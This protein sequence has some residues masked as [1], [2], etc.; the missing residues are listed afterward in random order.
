[1]A[2]SRGIRTHRR[3]AFV[4]IGVVAALVAAACG[5]GSKKA[6][7]STTET[8]AAGQATETSTTLAEGTTAPGETTTTGPAATGGGPATTTTAKASGST[9]K[10]TTATTARTT[11]QT[12]ASGINNVVGG[13]T[14]TA[15]QANVQVGG[16]FTYLNASD[17]A[18][19]DADLLGT[20]VPSDG[21]TGAALYDTLMYFNKAG[22]V[23]PQTAESLTSTDGL[24][25]TLKLR[26]NIKFTDGTPYDAAAVKFNFARIGDPAT[27]AQNAAFVSSID[28]MDVVDAQTLKITL[29]AKSG[30]FPNSVVPIGFVGS[31][32]AIQKDP[33][34]FANN[35]I[36]AGPFMFKS[37]VRNS[38]MTLVRNPN[39]WNAPEPYLDQLI[40]KPIQDEAQRVNTLN[41]GQA[42]MLWTRV[43]T[44]KA[45]A[46]GAGMSANALI[47]NGGTNAY[48]N[49]TT[50]P[51][52]DQ[53]VR[54][55]V[56]RAIDRAA[57]ANIV[58]QNAAPPINSIF[59]EQSPFYDQ[60]LSQFPYDP[61]KAQQLFDAAAADLGGPVTFEISG[62]AVQTQQTQAEY[63]QGVLR[64]YRNVKVTVQTYA[65]AAGTQKLNS[66]DFQMM[67]AGN[68]F[69]DPEP[70]FTSRYVCT[71]NPNSTG[72]CDSNFDA[73]VNTEKSTLDPNQ[74]ISAL[75][76][77][78][79]IFYAAAP[80]IYYDRGYSWMMTAP[81]VQNF[82][83]VNDGWVLFDRIWLKTH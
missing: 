29:K 58:N 50:A 69:I 6:T 64:N 27:K 63:M 82:N 7:T 71:A 56:V 12:L 77:A 61:T 32:T 3:I 34:A 16:T 36:G 11:K 21:V 47:T 78:Q 51:F 46:E 75:K 4:G 55:A 5:G 74:R 35:P 80:S 18:T 67:L 45:T 20:S 79:R 10:A 83:F 52:K 59:S 62:F 26:P 57:Y 19:V 43:P 17:P 76:D 73:D 13:G 44:S 30:V 23:T 54:E 40:I 68:Y 65:I 70:A 38:A 37:W 24:V 2:A 66:R 41:A 60:S 1:M 31:P 25:W 72:W 22:Q 9:K 14:T 49:T 53:R 28:H 33:N 39:Y 42:Q 15:P 8:T 48:F 81:Q